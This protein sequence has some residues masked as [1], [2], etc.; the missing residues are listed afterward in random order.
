MQ[1]KQEDTHLQ[2]KTAKHHKKHMKFKF[3]DYLKAII[4]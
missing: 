1:K 4:N 2:R 3:F